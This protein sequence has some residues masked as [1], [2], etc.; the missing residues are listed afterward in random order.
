MFAWCRGL[1]ASNRRVLCLT[2]SSLCSVPRCLTSFPSPDKRN[3]LASNLTALERTKRLWSF[4]NK[5]K[6]NRRLRLPHVL[7]RPI[8]N[9]PTETYKHEK[10]TRGHGIDSSRSSTVVQTRWILLTHGRAVLRPRDFLVSLRDTDRPTPQICILE[11]RR[12]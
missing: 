4:E 2:E 12:T 10:C 7:V 6:A 5:Y 8:D 9:S 1:F 11:S 3:A